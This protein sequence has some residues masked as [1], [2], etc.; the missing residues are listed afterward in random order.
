LHFVLELGIERDFN[1]IDYPYLHED[2]FGIYTKTDTIEQF[3]QTKLAVINFMQNDDLESYEEMFLYF[4]GLSKHFGFTWGQ[5][6]EAYFFKNAINH[7]RQ[8]NG[9]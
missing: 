9:Y 6:E 5:I 2:N 7:E 1:E 4:I 8:S 3:I